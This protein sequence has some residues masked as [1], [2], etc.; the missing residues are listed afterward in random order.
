[1]SHH[2]KLEQHISASEEIQKLRSENLE[3]RIALRLLFE[4]CVLSGNAYAKGYGW[5]KAI[6]AA[7]VALTPKVKDTEDEQRSSLDGRCTL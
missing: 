3:L 6:A 7:R 5:P 4:E 2:Y 1:M